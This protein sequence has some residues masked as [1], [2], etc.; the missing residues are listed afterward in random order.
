M[1]VGEIQYRTH[2]PWGVVLVHVAL[3]GAVWA[4]S[5]AFITLL[6]RARRFMPQGAT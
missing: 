5:V 3:A 1:I 4:G 6:W 2:L